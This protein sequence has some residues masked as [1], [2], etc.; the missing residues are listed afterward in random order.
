MVWHVLCLINLNSGKGIISF[1]D[2]CK[3]IDILSSSSVKSSRVG[4]SGIRGFG[5]NGSGVIYNNGWFVHE[6]LYSIK[7]LALS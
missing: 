1:I 4:G 3:K 6:K 2:V 7:L 5:V